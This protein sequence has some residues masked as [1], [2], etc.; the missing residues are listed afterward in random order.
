MRIGIC[1]YSFHNALADG[2][3]DIFTYIDDCKKLG[4][5]Q[6]DP[7]NAHLLGLTDP[8]EIRFVG[9]NPSKADLG[10]ADDAYIEKVKTK[11]QETGLPIGCIA[12]DGAYIYDEDP[13]KM[14]KNRSVAYRWIEIAGYL[15]AEHVRIDAGGP[16]EMPEDIFKRIKDGYNDIISRAEK[17]SV[18]VLIENHWGPSPIPEN[19]VKILTEIEN[20]GLLFD[21]NNWAEGH[22]VEG[23]EKCAKYAEYTHVKTFSFD[24]NGNEPSVD[25]S[26]PIAKLREEGFD[27]CWGVE[28]VPRDGTPEFEAAKLTIELI[29]R[30]VETEQ[31]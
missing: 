29:R 16:P 25:L 3:G 7:W 28:S 1:S 22:Q 8:E 18:K 11:A 30:N 21:T 10:A 13:D 15:G 9:H 2:K 27:G 6:I 24:E 5:T 31:E 20:L 19:L 12:V 17:N 14:K 23:W 4:C 26:I